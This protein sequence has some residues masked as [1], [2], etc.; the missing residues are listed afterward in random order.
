MEDQISLAYAV[1][2]EKR[3]CVEEAIGLPLSNNFVPF[4]LLLQASNICAFVDKSLDRSPKI[5]VPRL[6][7]NRSIHSKIINRS[8]RGKGGT[9]GVS[10]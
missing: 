8:V 9:Y 7:F 1:S 3:M 4:Y 6:P 5:A 10:V 2:S